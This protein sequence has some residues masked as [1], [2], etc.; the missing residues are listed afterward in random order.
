MPVGSEMQLVCFFI[1]VSLRITWSDLG[2]TLMGCVL[3]G[4]L[5]CCVKTHLNAPDKTKMSK[6]STFTELITLSD[7]PLKCI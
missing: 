4:R 6:T 3:L 2:L 7:D 1:A 5:C